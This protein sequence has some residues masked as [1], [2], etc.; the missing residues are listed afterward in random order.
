MDKV[1]ETGTHYDTP[2]PKALKIN[3]L[4]GIDLSI[5]YL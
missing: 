2:S 5:S 1:E 4:I 3:L